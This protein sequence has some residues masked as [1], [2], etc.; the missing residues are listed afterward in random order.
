M[1]E[2]CLKFGYLAVSKRAQTL[3]LASIRVEAGF[4]INIS[5]SS[6]YGN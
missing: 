5:L 6:I 4:I 1:K 3:M 2:S